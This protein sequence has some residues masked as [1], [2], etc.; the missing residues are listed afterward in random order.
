MKK[1]WLGVLAVALVGI[2]QYAQAQEVR[3][4]N[5]VGFYKVNIPPAGGMA[6]CALQFNSIDPTN[7]TLLGIFGTNNL[8]KSNFPANADKVWLWSV[9][10]STWKSYTQN[11]AGNFVPTNA[12]LMTGDAFF[13]QSPTFRA[14]TNVVTFAGEVVTDPSIP[15]T[16]IPGLQAIGYPFSAGTGLADMSIATNGTG[17]AFPNNADHVFIY[18][19]QAGYID[20]TLKANKTWSR[21]TPPAANNVNPPIALGQGFW[22][23]AKNQ[24][25]WVETNKY[26]QS[27]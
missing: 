8:A 21:I 27:L 19:S 2:L 3:S 22:Y 10:S 23:K 1:A 18:D 11:N 15:T 4:V 9:A 26:L 5:V 7:Q 16:I 17:N 25:E 14:T 24:F 13:L 6:L 12:P 20:Y